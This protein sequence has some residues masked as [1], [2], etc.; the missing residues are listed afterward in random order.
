LD[1]GS[2]NGGFMDAIFLLFDG[3]HSWLFWDY[4]Q[5]FHKFEAEGRKRP[6]VDWCARIKS[7]QWWIVNLFLFF[8]TVYFLRVQVAYRYGQIKSQ[9]LSNVG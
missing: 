5:V 7:G 4:K 8:L 3:M 9:E 1:F 6:K 2:G